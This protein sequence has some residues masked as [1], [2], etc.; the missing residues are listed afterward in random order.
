MSKLAPRRYGDKL[1]LAG[2]PESPLQ[3]MHREV[4]VENLSDEALDALQRFTQALME[5]APT[6][7]QDES[8]VL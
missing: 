6:K 8:N 7:E 4:S 5:S 3:V 2:D 1:Q